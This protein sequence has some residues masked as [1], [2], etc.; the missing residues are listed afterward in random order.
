M[1][2]VG[3]FGGSFDPVHVGHLRAAIEVMEHLGLD[4]LRFIPCAHSPGKPPPR[5][6]G[7]LR[8]DWLELAMGDRPGWILDDR[9]LRREGVSHTVETLLGI[10]EEEPESRL[11][12]IVGSDAFSNLHQW[13]EAD[14]LGR[15][16]HWIVLLRP[17]FPLVLPEEAPGWCRTG[18]TEDPARLRQDPAG[19]VLYLR[20]TALGI[21][22]T[23]IRD[24]IRRGLALDYLVPDSLQDA[25]ARAACYDPP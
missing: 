10:R 20:V 12:W 3:L 18:R 17:G 1:R 19:D 5:A 21:S 16:A 9:E 14:R 15:L 2:H 8:R 13:R 7:R 11:Y 25:L 6:S 22:A 23:A 24:R 4:E